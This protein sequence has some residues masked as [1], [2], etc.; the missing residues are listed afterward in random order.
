MRDSESNLQV[1]PLEVAGWQFI[2]SGHLACYCTVSE[3]GLI[4]GA[5][6]TTDN[7]SCRWGQTVCTGRRSQ[8]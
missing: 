3:I 7:W 4:V 1:S 6:P 8:G 5:I 2:P